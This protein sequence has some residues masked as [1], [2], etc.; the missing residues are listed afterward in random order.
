MEQ[1]PG[2]SLLVGPRAMADL[3]TELARAEVTPEQ[4]RSIAALAKDSASDVGVRLAGGLLVFVRANPG[5]MLVV[6]RDGAVA[7]LDADYGVP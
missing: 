5:D 6:E 1:I 2:R 3:A 7:P 4:L